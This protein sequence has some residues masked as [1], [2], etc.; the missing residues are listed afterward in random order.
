[1]NFLVYAMAAVDGWLG[2]RGLANL[3]G[4]L[5]TS[6]YAT[7]TTAVFTVGCLAMAVGGVWAAV[8]GYPGYGLLIVFG[9][10]LLLAA[11]QFAAMATG[12]YQ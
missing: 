12:S 7:G 6:K 1:M 2:L 8:A 3:V 11:V 10:W 9:P 5:R 4:I